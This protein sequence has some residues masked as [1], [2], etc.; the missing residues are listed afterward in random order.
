MECFKNEQLQFKVYILVMN[1]VFEKVN[2]KSLKEVYDLKGST[3]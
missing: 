2:L 3:F 1:N